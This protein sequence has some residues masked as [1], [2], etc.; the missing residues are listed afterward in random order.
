M[1]IRIKKLAI[2]VTF[3]YNEDRLQYLRKISEEFPLLAESVCVHVFTN[4]GDRDKKEIIAETVRQGRDFDVQV[5]TPTYLGHPF[6]LTWCHFYVFRTLF[7]SN[8]DITHFMYLEDDILVKP[9]NIDYWLRSYEA[10]K[11]FNLIP[12]FLRYDTDERSMDIYSTDQRQK[13][14]FSQLAKVKISNDYYF[15]N[16]IDGYQGMYLLDRELMDQHL[17]GPSSIPE[18]SYFNGIREKAAAGLS[19]TNVPQGCLHRLFTGYDLELQRIDPGS[20]IHHLQSTHSRAT[21]ETHPVGYIK[22]EDLIIS[23]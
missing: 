16:L 13:S 2:A 9:I 18:Y 14:E 3:H 12:A 5:H 10:L 15:L 19:H 7:E 8:K 17:N 4:K 11:I 21:A 23:S 20:L 1:S 6:L 22:V